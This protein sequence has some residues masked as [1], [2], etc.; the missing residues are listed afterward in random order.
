[1]SKLSNF[2][3]IFLYLL[4]Y[5]AAA[6][7]NYHMF[8]LT[9]YKARTYLRGF[10]RNFKKY[11]LG[12]DNKSPLYYILRVI[13]LWPQKAKKPLVHTPRMIRMFVT[14]TV[15]LALAV[16]WLF[17]TKNIFLMIPFALL[18]ALLI[19]VFVLLVNFLNSPLENTINN[20]YV[21][22][23]KRILREMPRLIV[24]GVTGSYGK[25]SIKHFLTKLLSSKFNTLMTPESYNTTMGVVKT[26]RTQLRS[27]HDIF[28]CEMG[29]RNRGDIKEICDIVKPRCGVITAIGPQH[30]ESFKTIDNIVKTK[31]ELADALPDDGIIFLNYDSEILRNKN[32]DRSRVSYAASAEAGACDYSAGNVSVSD[33]GSSF[34]VTFPD[35]GEMAFETSLIGKHN[36][37]NIA[38]AIA[39]ADYFGVERSDMVMSVRRLEAVPH[40]LQL[41]RRNNIILIDDSY[42]SN[43]SGA[44][45]ALEVLGMFDGVR[46]LVTP[47]MVELG[48]AE[49]DSNRRFGEQAGAVCDYVVLVGEK[50]TRSIWKGLKDSAYPDEKIFVAETLQ[51]AL[52]AV[53]TIDAGGRQKIVLLENDLPDNY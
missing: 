33:A 53:E 36:V 29:A 52:E 49:D 9:S 39:V 3:L 14:H 48:S 5:C 27:I 8:Q 47:G 34:R 44:K 40:R 15:I 12:T 28:V 45:A 37:Q 42:N 1:M 35:G 38:G 11:Y 16:L 26:I 43:E 41:I 32:Y 19:P 25:T 31:F 23:A 51:Q 24:I 46:I 30:L 17:S 2:F 50:Q 6:L 4:L 7:Y 20:W 21:A 18:F 22:D 13:N 10:T